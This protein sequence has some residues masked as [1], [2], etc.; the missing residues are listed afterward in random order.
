MV[1]TPNASSNK[2][3]VNNLATTWTKVGITETGQKWTWEIFI[4]TM[5]SAFS[6]HT[7]I[8]I[9]RRKQERYITE[10]YTVDNEYSR[11][12]EEVLLFKDLNVSWRLSEML[13]LEMEYMFTGNVKITIP[14]LN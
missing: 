1:E 14:V 3:Q 4:T 12:E 2:K 6:H 11:S 9:L 10:C 8:Q 13:K 5:E 7:G